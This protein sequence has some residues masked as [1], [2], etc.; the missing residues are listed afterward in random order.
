MLN[1]FLLDWVQMRLQ[2]TSA[3]TRA[4]VASAI[5]YTFTDTDASYDDI[6]A[7]IIVEFLQLM[8]DPD[9]VR[10]QSPPPAACFFSFFLI[11][12]S[13]PTDA[14]NTLFLATM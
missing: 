2:S 8:Q 9:L 10:R 13:F 5:R 14:R 1:V 3:K 11:R 6:L 12:V 7:P 4:T